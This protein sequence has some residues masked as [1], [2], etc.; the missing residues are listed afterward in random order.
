M[1]Q[2]ERKVLGTG[3]SALFGDLSPGAEEMTTLSLSR[4]EPREEQ[5]RD[6]FDEESLQNLADSISRY[7]VLQPIT[8]RLLDSGYYQIIAGERR[9]RASRLAGLTE[10]PVRIIEADDRTTA[11]LALVE[12]LQRED[13]NPIEEAKGYKTLIEDFGLTQEEAA[14]SVGK[15]RPAVTNALR[16]LSLSPD[17]LHLVETGDLSAG[18]ARALLPLQDAEIQL[19]AAKEIMAKALSVRKA[20]SLASKVLKQSLASKE[21]QNSDSSDPEQIDYAKEVSTL[22]TKKLGRKVRLIEGKNNLGKIELEYYNADDR[23]ALLSLLNSL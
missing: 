22:L 21:E 2:K 8:V 5:P 23:E 19:T 20:E 1:A 10:V 7:G 17:V 15:S 9:W 14:K 18:H 16:L 3:L 4:I 12:N 11:E 6:V 13:L